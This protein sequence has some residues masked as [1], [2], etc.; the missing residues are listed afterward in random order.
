MSVTTNPAVTGVPNFAGL[1][2][3]SASVGTAAVN[4]SALTALRSDAAPAIAL[5]ISPTWTGTHAFNNTIVGSISGNAATATLATSATSAS[6]AG[7]APAS[8]LTGTTLAAGVTASSLTSVGTLT[9]LT[10]SGNSTLGDSSSDTLN[11]GN[12]D[13]IKDSSGRTGIGV[14]PTVKLHVKS[15]ADLARIETTSARGSGNGYLSFADPTGRKAYFGY[16]NTDDSFSLMNEMNDIIKLGTNSVF[17][18]II[19]AGGQVACQTVGAGLSVKEGSNAKQGTATLVAGTVTVAN[20]SVTAS[21]RIFLTTQ[22][23]GTVAAPK[24]IAVTA[25]VAATSFTITSEDATD[26][27]VIAYEIFEPS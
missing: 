10:I 2:D 13:L 6:T 11:V 26:T 23:L 19:S 9:S 16:G 7:S 22:S 18:L 20:T 15:A 4:G 27:S 17:R 3:P 21:S 8:A 5:N 14:S 12:G 1:A 24:S 25:R